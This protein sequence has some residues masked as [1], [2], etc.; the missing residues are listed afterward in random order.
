ME[1]ICSHVFQ[2]MKNWEGLECV[3]ADVALKFDVGKRPLL[4]PGFQNSSLLLLVGYLILFPLLMSSIVNSYIALALS[5]QTMNYVKL[6]RVI[7]NCGL[8]SLSKSTPLSQKKIPFVVHAICIYFS[9]ISPTTS[10]NSHLHHLQLKTHV[11]L[12]YVIMERL[13]IA[14]DLKSNKRGSHRRSNIENKTL[15]PKKLSG[16]VT[17][18]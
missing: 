12:W 7:L 17:R 5:L 13:T 2:A 8:I 6:N 11:L 18:A 16:Y 14:H 9:P 10:D 4:R 1:L 15:I 3:E